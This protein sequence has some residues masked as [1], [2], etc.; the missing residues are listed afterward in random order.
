MALTTTVST[1]QAV[2]LSSSVRKKLL[3]KIGAYKALKAQLDPIK[4]K[5]KA[6]TEELGAI[7]DQETGEMSLELEGVGKITLVAGLY[8]KFNPKTFVSLGGDLAI[9]Q[10]AIDEKPRKAYNRISLVG[11]K[12]EEE[13]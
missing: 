8:K 6:L 1:T 5:M 2:T 9:Y 4:L 3:T 13:Y 10:Q 7:R 12:D 11:D